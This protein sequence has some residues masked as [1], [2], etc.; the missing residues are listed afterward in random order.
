MNAVAVVDD[1]KVKVVE[2][3]ALPHYTQLLSPERD[4]TL[5]TEAARGLWMLAFKCRDSIL[6]QPACLDGRYSLLTCCCNV[7]IMYKKRA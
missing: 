3:G 6:K 1:N 7:K 2:A 4:E 5:Q